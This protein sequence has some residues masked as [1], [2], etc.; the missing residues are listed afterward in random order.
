MR[1]ARKLV[2]LCLGVL[3]A[4]AFGTSSAS[5]AIAVEVEREG[6]THCT[7]TNPCQVVA[8]GESHLTLFGFVV[9]NCED[10]FTALINEDGTGHIIDADLLDHTG[11]GG[12][13]TRIPCNGIG[14]A[15]A[16]SE[17]PILGSEE[18]A[19]NEGTMDVRFCLDAADDPDGTG[20]HCT[21]PIHILERAAH[22][23][24]FSTAFTC[25]NLIRVEGHWLIEGRPIEIE[26]D[27]Q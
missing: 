24:E 5:A 10:E 23:Y 7:T 1:I 17:W 6:S 8:H 2:L 27:G 15:Q 19:P 21:A 16:E 13:C 9:S 26:H 3:A 11:T 12:D 18:T 4:M 25:P 22:D 14:E 20:T